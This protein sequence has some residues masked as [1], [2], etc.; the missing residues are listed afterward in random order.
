MGNSTDEMISDALFRD[1]KSMRWPTTGQW[2][3]RCAVTPFDMCSGAAASGAKLAVRS[4][5]VT[6]V[7]G[8]IRIS[9][10]TA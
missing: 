9:M 4:Y 5:P 2:R 8:S 1:G 6:A 3:A 7:R 10:P